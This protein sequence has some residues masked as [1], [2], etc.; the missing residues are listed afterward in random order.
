MHMTRG[1]GEVLRER[2]GIGNERIEQQR[3]RS[4]IMAFFMLVL[5]NADS[6]L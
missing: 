4:G 5:S 6:R 3:Q 2:E 1:A